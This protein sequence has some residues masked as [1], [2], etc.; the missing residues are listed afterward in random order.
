LTEVDF[1]TLTLPERIAWLHS[2]HGPNGKLSH[3]RFAKILGGTSRQAIINWEKPGGGEPRAPM[4]RKL[5]KFSG[6]RPEVFSRRQAEA[7][8]QVTVGSRLRSVED[9]AKWLR[10]QLL[11]CLD[12][13][14]LE[15]QEEPRA[16]QS[17]GAP[18]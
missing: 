1:L 16:A 13:L 4:R 7:L 3:D 12:A 14:E 10:S 2:E 8:E 17:G 6:F 9:E 11:R 5:A 15:P 18:Q